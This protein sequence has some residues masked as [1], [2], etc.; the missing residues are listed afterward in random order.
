MRLDL[1][2]DDVELMLDCLFALRLELLKTERI[3]MEGTP[4]D[5]R[6]SGKLRQL[7]ALAQKIT[8][9]KGAR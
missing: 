4:V 9:Q 1:S 8:Q 2:D 7:G 3:L 5:Q 6:V